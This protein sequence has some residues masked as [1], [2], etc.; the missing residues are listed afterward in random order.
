MVPLDN[1]DD[2]NILYGYILCISHETE[3][4]DANKYKFKV[5]KLFHRMANSQIMQILISK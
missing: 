3:N 2:R 5:R 1:V 4:V